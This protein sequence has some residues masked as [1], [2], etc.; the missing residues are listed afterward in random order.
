MK[1]SEGD[2]KEAWISSGLVAASEVGSGEVGCTRAWK[3]LREEMG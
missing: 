2:L 1:G 3:L